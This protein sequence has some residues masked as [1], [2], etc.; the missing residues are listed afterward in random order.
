VT[1]LHLA[2]RGLRPVVLEADPVAGGRLAGG[3]DVTLEAGG[4]RFFFPGEH[5][6]HGV[7][8][9]YRNLTALLAQ[10]GLA[11]RLIPARHQDWIYGEG[12]RVS[13]AELGSAVIKS[14]IPAPLH[15]LPMFLRP[16][17][18]AML[19]PR[20]HELR[21]SLNIA[22]L[23]DRG[24][25]FRGCDAVA[26]DPSRAAVDAVEHVRSRAS[27]WW[28]HTDLD[29]LA[30]GQL[31]AVDY[32]QPAGLTWGQ[33]AGLT[34]TALA[35]DGCAGWSVCIYNPDLDPGHDGAD[36]IISYITQAIIASDQP[37][38]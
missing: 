4:R 8:A 14:R 26:A 10:Y 6:I 1:A 3:V 20:D 27:S 33:L 35:A 31:A 18:L 21:R 24:V 22:S 5:G 29:V 34:A 37:A 11:S 2:E 28:L 30:T 12:T 15:Y 19:G 16:R 9:G 13:R 38:R 36:A 7:W 25:H 23:A 17:F 32:P